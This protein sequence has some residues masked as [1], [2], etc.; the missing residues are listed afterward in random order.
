[1]GPAF[2]LLKG[3]QSHFSPSQNKKDNWEALG[4]ESREIVP[5]NPGSP[6]NLSQRKQL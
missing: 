6:T 1:M 5:V 2:H 3:Q 4:G